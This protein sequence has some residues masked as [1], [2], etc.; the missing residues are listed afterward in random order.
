MPKK[1]DEPD[2]DKL[3]KSD[4]ELDE[5]N[6][7][8]DKSNDELD[9]LDKSNDELDEPDESDNELDKSNDESDEEPGEGEKYCMYSYGNMICRNICSIDD[10]IC[11]ECTY[12]NNFYI[13]ENR[14]THFRIKYTHLGLELIEC[15]G[16]SSASLLLQELAS[17]YIEFKYLLDNHSAIAIQVIKNELDMLSRIR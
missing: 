1:N 6:D 13:L 14:E 9:E 10:I 4:D 2:N 17:D 7:E 12:S 15:Y 5:P 16:S 3:D 11:R 8:L